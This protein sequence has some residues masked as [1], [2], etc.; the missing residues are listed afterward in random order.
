MIGEV[1]ILKVFKSKNSNLKIETEDN[2][3]V[4]AKNKQSN[5]IVDLNYYSL[6][7]KKENFNKRS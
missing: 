3:K 6:F 4:F 2:C 7:K 5:I 1:K